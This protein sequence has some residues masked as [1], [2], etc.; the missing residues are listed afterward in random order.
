MESYSMQPSLSMIPLRFIQVVC[1]SIM[2][3]FLLLHHVLWYGGT[4]V[5]TT[6]YSSPSTGGHLDHFQFGAFISKAALNFCVQILLEHSFHFSE[7]NA[8]V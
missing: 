8:Q 6:N 3:S 7:T 4:I 5:C 2:C 1:L